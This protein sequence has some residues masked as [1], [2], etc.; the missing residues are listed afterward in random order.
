[1]KENYSKYMEDIEYIEW[2]IVYDEIIKIVEEDQIDI[3][4]INGDS[5]DSLMYHTF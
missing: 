4:M 3:C 5:K 1:M 2:S